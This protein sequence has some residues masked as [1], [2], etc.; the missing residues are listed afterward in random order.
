LIFEIV[1]SLVIFTT[2]AALAISLKKNIE[3]MEKLEEV[4]QSLQMS[5]D[6]LEIQYEKLNKKS[7]IELFSDEPVVRDLVIDIAEAKEAVIVTARLLDGVLRTEETE[8]IE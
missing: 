2:S 3:Y 6:L 1:A 7:K 5:I 4:G 8:E